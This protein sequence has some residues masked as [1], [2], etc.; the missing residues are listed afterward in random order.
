M[1]I[2]HDLAE[3]WKAMAHPNGCHTCLRIERKYALDGYPPP[4]VTAWMS[5][6]AKEPGSGDDAIERMLGDGTEP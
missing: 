5:A 3:Y 4:I 6:E 2:E 1:S